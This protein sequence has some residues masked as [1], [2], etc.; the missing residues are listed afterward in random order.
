MRIAGLRRG[1][2]YPQTGGPG[3]AA[4]ALLN[5]NIAGLQTL[6]APFTPSGSLIAAIAFTPRVSGIVQVSGNLLL[7][8]GTDAETYI[9]A[10]GVE[11]YTGLTVTGGEV[12]DGGWVMGTTTPPVLGGAADSSILALEAISKLTSGE[13]GSMSFFGITPLALPIG[14]PSLVA[15]ILSQTGGG[16]ALAGVGIANLSVIELP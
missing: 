13:S 12:T 15:V 5:R 8:N 14:T 4:G 16:H 2:V 10:M 7:T 11:T 3:A 1:E 6:D 9:G